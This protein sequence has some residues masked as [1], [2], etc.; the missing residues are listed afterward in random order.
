MNVKKCERQNYNVDDYGCTCKARLFGGSSLRMASNGFEP[1]VY[2]LL[3]IG[4]YVFFGSTVPLHTAR[5]IE[6]TLF[7]L[8]LV[9]YELLKWLCIKVN[10]F[11]FL[12]YVSCIPI[13]RLSL[14]FT[15]YRHAWP[16][17]CEDHFY[18]FWPQFIT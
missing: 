5:I 1:N 6:I 8:K 11:Y 12:Y 9:I 3:F 7:A 17:Y 16:H 18:I 13:Q 2:R 10:L 14:E 15:I 4:W